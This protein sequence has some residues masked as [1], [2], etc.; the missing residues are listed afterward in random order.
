VPEHVVHW[1]EIEGERS[2]EG[3]F[4]STWT[5]L[6]GAAGT[7]TVGVNRVQVDPGARSTPLHMEGAEEEIFFVLEGSGLSWQDDGDG[8]KSYEIRAGDCLVHL[9]GAEAHSV[10]AGADGID[11]LAFGTRAKPEYAF[12]PRLK[13]GRIGMLWA[14]MIETHQWIQELALGEPELPEPSP[15][16]RRIVNVD[17]LDEQDWGEG[18]VLVHGRDLGIAAGSEASGINYNRIEP[19]K[20]SAPPHC[21]SAEEEIFVI[22]AGGGTALLGEEEHP[23]RRGHVIARPAATRIA[24]AFRAATD[25]LTMLAY[26]TRDRG[27]D[28]VYYPRSE[29]LFFRGV[30]VM[31]RVEQLGYWADENG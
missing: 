11:Y 17:E 4:R 7:V 1:D 30:G 10:V 14:D 21:H 27:A 29:K 15:R 13:A 12:F 19:G 5:D 24:H 26:G 8:E 20:L 31:T 28:I 2:D 23:I 9:A 6:G 3:A 18:D 16:P 22:L 25:G